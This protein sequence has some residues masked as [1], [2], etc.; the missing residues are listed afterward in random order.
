MPKIIDSE[1]VLGT[2]S[3][4]RRALDEK[5]E[6]KEHE[7]RTKA[8]RLRDVQEQ[9]GLADREE[10]VQETIW[11]INKIKPGFVVQICWKYFDESDGVTEELRWCCGVV[12][13]I[14]RD[15]SNDKSFFE[16]MVQWNDEFVEPG[17]VNPTC[18]LLK[19]NDYNPKRHYHGA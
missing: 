7:I 16:V 9:M 18:E 4:T 12:Q 11:P 5:V 1:V 14:V 10:F 15:K 8:R 17:M 2:K 6:N 13:S 19:K 3:V